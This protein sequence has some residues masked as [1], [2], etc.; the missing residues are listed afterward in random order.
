MFYRG[1]GIM[2]LEIFV[3]EIKGKGG[4]TKDRV[5]SILADGEEKT[6]TQL[7]R[8]IKK[9]YGISVTFQAVLKAV[10]SLETM[11]VVDRKEKRYELNTDWII[12]T[13]WFFD[14]LYGDRI[15]VKKPVRKNELGKNV[16]IY[17]VHNLLELDRLWNDLLTN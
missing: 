10:R 2:A 3:P 17:E 16:V 11:D 15:G 8:E 14:R 1:E 9:R 5:F 7:H 6:I 13:R 12:E 4:S